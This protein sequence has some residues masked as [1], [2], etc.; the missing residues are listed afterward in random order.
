MLGAEPEGIDVVAGG[1]ALHDNPNVRLGWADV[2]GLAWNPFSEVYDVEA[3]GD[4]THPRR[5]RGQATFNGARGGAYRL[6]SQARRSHT[7]GSRSRV[8]SKSA[9]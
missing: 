8:R 5:G 4:A 6:A 9:W 7:S 2:L 3:I 1:L